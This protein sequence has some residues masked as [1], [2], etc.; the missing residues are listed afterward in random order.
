MFIYTYLISNVDFITVFLTLIWYNNI[1]YN[2]D[3]KRRRVLIGYPFRVTYDL[4]V[5]SLLSAIKSI[6]GLL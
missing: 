4:S 1:L 5:Y 3:L 2:I 6:T